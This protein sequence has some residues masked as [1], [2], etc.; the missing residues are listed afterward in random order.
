MRFTFLVLG[1]LG[2]VVYKIVD[3]PFVGCI[4]VVE[5]VCLICSDLY[6]L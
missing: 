5:G 1:S 4:V 3:P 2:L 6:V